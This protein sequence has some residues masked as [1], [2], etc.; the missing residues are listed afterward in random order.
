MGDK[1]LLEY[2]AGAVDVD[3][4]KAGAVQ[5]VLCIGTLQSVADVELAADVG[6]TEGRVACREIWIGERPGGLRR[7]RVIFVEHVDLIVV[8]V[9]GEKKVC[10]AAV[11]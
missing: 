2:A 7:E 4:A 1:P 11:S 8:E 6:D 5:F 3:E 9:G 10:A